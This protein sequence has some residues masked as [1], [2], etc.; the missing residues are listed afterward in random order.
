M[1]RFALAYDTRTGRKQRVPK[2]W[3]G[4]PVLGAH[5]RPVPSA[6][7]EF[8]PSSEPSDRW[9]VAQLKEYAAAHDV[10]VDGVSRKADLLA[11][12]TNN[13]PAPDAE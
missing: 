5:I 12:I 1:S 4:H 11:A 3:F 2:H 8:D 9:T 13:D 6:G 10:D 7:A